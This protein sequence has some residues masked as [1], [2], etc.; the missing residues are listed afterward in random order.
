MKTLCV[1]MNGQRVATWHTRDASHWLTYD[2]S[3]TTSDR[4]RSLSLSLPLGATEIKGEA[5]RNYFDNLLPDSEQ[6]RQRLRRRYKTASTEVVDLLEAIGRDCVGAVQLLPEG[7]TPQGWDSIAGQPLSDHDVAQILEG[8]TSDGSSTLQ[9]RHWRPLALGNGGAPMWEAMRAFV[10]S[11][12]AAL[13]R[14]QAELPA[15]FPPRTWESVTAGMRQHASLFN[16]QAALLQ[17]KG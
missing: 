10:E 14:V 15:D 9:A 4:A 11:V 13:D 17:K 12:E 16:R 7:V 5:V 6:I 1:W 8:V 3:W 2:D